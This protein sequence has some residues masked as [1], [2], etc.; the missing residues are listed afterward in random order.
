MEKAVKQPITQFIPQRPPFVMIDELLAASET[1]ATSAFKIL[2]ENI[3]V[4]AGKLTETG[5]IENIA[6]TAAAMVGYQCSIQQVPVPVGF[7]AAVKDL[8][9]M[10]LPVVETVI[11]TQIQVTNTVMDVTIVQGR[12]EQSG[13][14]LCSCEMRILVQKSVPANHV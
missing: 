8:K 5:L 4:E 12:V 6:Q 9:V 11:Q 1:E 7:I 13:K 14:L 2:Q 3:L 10:A